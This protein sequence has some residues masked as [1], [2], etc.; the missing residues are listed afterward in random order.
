MGFSLLGFFAF[1]PSCSTEQPT[2]GILVVTVMDANGNVL[3]YEQVFLASSY[4][5]LRNEEYLMT[6]WTD[7]KGEVLFMNLL[8]AF[9]WYDTQHWEDYGAA[10]VWAGIEHY[11][12]LWVNTPQP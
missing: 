4:Q 3:P 2:H 9:Y 8:P 1:L 7:E 12:I 11:V 10:Q 5:N 6:G